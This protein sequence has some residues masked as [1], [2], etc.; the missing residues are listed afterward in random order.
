MYSVS[1]NGNKVYQ[2]LEQ[3]KAKEFYNKCVTDVAKGIVMLSWMAEDFIGATKLYLKVSHY[4][5]KE[6][7]L[8]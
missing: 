1:V 2:N 6:N 3:C 4:N 5:R 7:D 8:I